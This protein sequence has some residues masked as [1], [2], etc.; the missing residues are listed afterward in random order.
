MSVILFAHSLTSVTSLDPSLQHPCLPVSL[1]YLSVVPSFTSSPDCLPYPCLP[2]SPPPLFCACYSVCLPPPPV[3]YGFTPCTPPSC[4]QVFPLT[5]CT[6]V[7]ILFSNS[8]TCI[9]PPPPLH[10]NPI[11]FLLSLPYFVSM[12]L[13]ATHN[14]LYDSL[15]ST[16][17]PCLCSYPLPQF[18][19]C[20]YCDW[21][22]C[23]V[24]VLRD[25]VSFM[26]ADHPPYNSSLSQ[27]MHH[28]LVFS[29]VPLPS[30]VSVIPFTNTSTCISPPSVPLLV[31]SLT[32]PILCVCHSLHQHF[33]L[34]LPS[35]CATPCL[36][37]NSSPPLC[38]LFL[39]PT[40][41]PVS[42][43]PLCDSLSSL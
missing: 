16:T 19:V 31:F 43:L 2:S 40:L 20:Y 36:L 10:H 37:S 22:F 23:V 4:F 28:T 15:P 21:C 5:C 1:V 33:H 41:Q 12:I 9:T 24:V 27:Y 38:Q 11:F 30:F 6:S 14:H 29:L 8:P 3:M 39:S 42:P 7:I 17:A 32:P 25:K 13:F 18:C 35:L 34:Y 26:V